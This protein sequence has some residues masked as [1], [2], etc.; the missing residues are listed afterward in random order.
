MDRGQ[1]GSGAEPG[2]NGASCWPTRG[3]RARP[4]R[5]AGAAVT[6]PPAWPR[7]W[8]RSSGRCGSAR[9]DGVGVRPGRARR[10]SSTA[11]TALKRNASSGRPSPARSPGASCSASRAPGSD[12][13]GLTTRAERAAD[14]WLVT[15]QKVWNTAAPPRGLRA[16]A[17]PHRLRRAQAPRHHLLRAAD[18][19]AGRRGAPAAA[20]ERALLVQRGVPGPG[21]GPGRPPDRRGGRRLDGGADHPGPRAPSRRVPA[22]PPAAPSPATAGPCGRRAAEADRG[23]RA[24]QLVPAA[25]RPAR[26]GHRPRIAAGAWRPTRWS[27]R[28][29]PGW[30][31]WPGPRGGRPQRAAA[32][33]AAGRPPGPGRLAGQAGQQH[34]RP[35]GG[36]GTRADRRAAGHAG[37]ARR[38]AGRDRSPR[39]SCRCRP[40]PSPAAPTR[41]SARSSASGSSASPEPDPG[42]R[43]R[44]AR[45]P[46]PPDGGGHARIRR[47]G[48]EAAR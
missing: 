30:S 48:A 41:S 4:G 15:G 21:Q 9:P 24:A 2:A 20:D 3:G 37:R 23:Q 28:R 39:S 18:A 5:A 43:R 7:W 35:A 14:G 11:P 42:R 36:A 1:L 10:S 31:S 38:A 46:E 27:A 32:A 26:P 16:A 6:C 19:P 12:L 45:C 33:R 34:H 25:G 44:S 47:V 13:A 29:L 40:S 22:R 8:G 17:G